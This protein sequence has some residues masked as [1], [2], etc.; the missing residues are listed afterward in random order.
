M[1]EI[2]KKITSGS[3]FTKSIL[4]IGKKMVKFKMFHEMS[5]ENRFENFR[6][7]RSQSNRTIVGGIRVV[8]LLMNR[9]NKW[10]FP[11]SRIR[12]GF[13][14]KAKETTKDRGQFISKFLEESGRDAIRPMGLVRLEIV[15]RRTD[16]T[17]GHNYRRHRSR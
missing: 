17:S 5:I 12:F 16:P 14:D 3:R 2:G 15:E 9:L 6:D 8:T 13:E 4:M 10:V 11:R 7:S 1:S